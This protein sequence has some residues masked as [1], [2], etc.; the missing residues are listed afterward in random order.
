MKFCYKRT[1][2]LSL[3]KFG[4]DSEQLFYVEHL[5]KNDADTKIL[6]S[7]SYLIFPLYHFSKCLYFL[8]FLFHLILKGRFLYEK[9]FPLIYS[10]YLTESP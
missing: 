8:I 2:Q 7:L 9:L 10:K 1:S 4:N 5:W 3:V 6:V